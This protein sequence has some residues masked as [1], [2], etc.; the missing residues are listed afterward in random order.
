[1]STSSDPALSSVA[2]SWRALLVGL[3]ATLRALGALLFALA[4]VPFGCLRR[5]HA[6]R[7]TPASRIPIEVHLTD[8]AQ[9]AEIEQAV[10]ATLIRCARTW[11]PR[12]LPL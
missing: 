11:A 8:P 9:A 12:P 4:R 2:G 10:R 1:M 7:P 5:P 3:L 6:S